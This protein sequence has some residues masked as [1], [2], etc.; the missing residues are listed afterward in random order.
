MTAREANLLQ[1]KFTKPG[2]VDAESG[3]HN[4]Q[5][6]EAQDSAVEFVNEGITIVI[7]QYAVYSFCFALT[8]TILRLRRELRIR[9]AESK[10]LSNTASTSER[11]RSQH[12]VDTARVD[13]SREIAEWRGMQ[14]THMP[15][16]A[17]G[18]ASETG[19]LGDQYGLEELIH[20][21]DDILGLPSDFEES[22]RVRLN[23]VE[24]ADIERQLLEGLAHDTLA[25]VRETLKHKKSLYRQKEKEVRGQGANTIANNLLAR[26]DVLAKRAAELYNF[27]RGRLLLLGM[28]ETDDTFKVIMVPGDLWMY[29]DTESRTRN[30]E[31]KEKGP[32]PWYWTVKALANGSDKEKKEWSLES[33]CS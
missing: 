24:L 14:S 5:L 17:T 6:Q 12:A 21:E 32:E 2:V 11:K 8:N 19:E 31:R 28:L 9:V 7:K 1:T 3:H 13:L 26:S 15:S 30:A 25:D 23:L 22:D 10:E 4:E 27:I 16:V 20:P 33:E 18:H 29:G